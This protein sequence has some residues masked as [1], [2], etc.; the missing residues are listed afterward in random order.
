MGRFT[1]IPTDTFDNLQL[2]AGVLLNTFDPANPRAPRDSEIITA[3]TGGI[4]AKLEPTYSDFG[5]DVDNCP[6]RVKELQHL[7]SWLGSIT[8]TALE[9]SAD[10]IK[11]AV[12][13]A[14]ITEATVYDKVTPR[15][16]LSQLDFQTIWWVG[17]KADGGAIAIELIN[18]LS[19]GGFDLKTTKSGKGQLSCTITGFVSMANQNV[20]PLNIYSI[21]PP[22]TT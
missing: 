12:G 21:D 5:E 1:V 2:D 16:N 10:V 8:F 15:R 4:Q 22:E 14:D 11:M 9:T 6:I 18:A 20:V 19:T 7:D 17:D 3:T 13:A